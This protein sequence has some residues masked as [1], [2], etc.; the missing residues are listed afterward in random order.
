MAGVA[1]LFF[2]GPPQPNLEEG[3]PLLLSGPE[4]KNHNT[5]VR[6]LR[7]LHERLSRLALVLIFLGFLMMLFATWPM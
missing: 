2:Y 3:W 4:A 5:E 7:S 6:G 1:L